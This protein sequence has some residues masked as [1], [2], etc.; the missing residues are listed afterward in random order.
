MPKSRFTP[1]RRITFDPDNY[2]TVQGIMQ[3]C[4]V[5]LATAYK[6]G[7]QHGRPVHYLPLPGRSRKKVA[8][9]NA[10]AIRLWEQSRR[11]PTHCQAFNPAHFCPAAEAAAILHCTTANIFKLAADGTISY[12]QSRNPLT[13]LPTR[14]YSRAD[15]NAYLRAGRAKNYYSGK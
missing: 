12:V 6:I 15:L 4:N 14:Y 13:N 5:K 11:I 10:K 1:L 2:I 7:Q 8:H 9:Y 3:L